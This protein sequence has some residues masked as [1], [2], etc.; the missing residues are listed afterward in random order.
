MASLGL[1]RAHASG[2]RLEAAH[3]PGI[4]PMP[5]SSATQH[6]EVWP[7]LPWPAWK[8]TQLSLHLM[9]Q[10]VGKLRT[11][12]AP[13]CNH[14][15]HVTLYL[16]ARGLT[17]SP[18]THSG[19][20]FQVDFDFID[21]VLKIECADGRTRWVGL[22]ARPI[23]DF[24]REFV[25]RLHEL[26]IDVHM[27]GKPNEMTHAIPFDQDRVHAA[28]DPG[29]VQRYWHA[30]LQVDRVFKLFRSR[31]IGKVSP[32]HFFWGSFDLAVTR[33]SG[34]TAPPHPGGVPNCPDWVMREAYSHEVSSAGFWPGNEALPFAAFY[35]YAYPQAAGFE[36][37]SVQP[38][39]TYWHEGLGEF[40]LPYEALR[41]SAN[42]DRDLLDFLQSTYEAAAQA[43]HWDRAA[44]ERDLSWSPGSARP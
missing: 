3:T 30:L 43:S 40:I 17:T 7:D 8:D 35:S 29:T 21:H 28:Y 22:C 34:R 10:I 4:L 31:Y 37:A 18:L 5:N 41:H 23:A 27:H 38:A 2:S 9:T 12:V 26:G 19:L 13:D 42:P 6:A 1:V 20:T 39:A 25:A 33:F 24:Y 15:W 14:C 11:A 32:V 16:S 44:L 36:R